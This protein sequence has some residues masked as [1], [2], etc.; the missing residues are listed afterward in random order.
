M[1]IPGGAFEDDA[2]LIDDKDDFGDIPIDDGWAAA[3]DDVKGHIAAVLGSDD[4]PAEDVWGTEAD[5]TPVEDVWGSALQDVNRHIEAALGRMSREGTARREGTSSATVSP[6]RGRLEFSSPARHKRARSIGLLRGDEDGVGQNSKRART[7]PES[8]FDSGIVTPDDPEGIHALRDLFAQPDP[9]QHTG[10]SGS[11]SDSD[12]EDLETSEQP[13][14]LLTSTTQSSQA[15]RRQLAEDMTTFL[16]NDQDE[17]S[18]PFDSTSF[19]I[20]LREY[21]EINTPIYHR[22]DARRFTKCDTVLREW[23]ELH[24]DVAAVKDMPHGASVRTE[25]RRRIEKI[26]GRYNAFRERRVGARGEDGYEGVSSEVVLE[27]VLYS[28]MTN[29]GVDVEEDFEDEGGL[30][31][32]LKELDEGVGKMR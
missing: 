11:S 18:I 31:E 21:W 10:D 12:P 25:R 9:T 3:V 26:R 13:P 28:L 7:W 24:L 19:L 17:D 4:A 30:G 5:G 8:R 23:I 29:W 32:C 1:D 2:I 27:Y 16:I 15:Y 22:F 14:K 20:C 6:P